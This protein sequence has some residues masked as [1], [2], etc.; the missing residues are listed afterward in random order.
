MNISV[1]GVRAQAHA[2]LNQ[3]PWLLDIERQYGLP[4]GLLIGVGSRETNGHNIVGDDGHGYGVWQRDNRSWPIDRSYLDNVRKQATDAA[5]LL[6]T[7]YNA[8]KDWH[9]A[10][11][12]YN[13][14]LGAVKS[15]VKA[16]KDPDS[17]TTGYD[18]GKDVEQRRQT[19]LPIL[20]GI[21]KP[22]A[23]PALKYYT[24][25]SGDTLS[26][27]ATMNNVSLT[28][29]WNANAHTLDLEAKKRGHV[30]SSRG[31]VIFPGTKVVLP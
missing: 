23:A 5:S 22:K 15:A 16:G 28:A 12:A 27:I 6:R 13:C 2:M 9:G 14:G 3:W 20:P 18:Y 30:G 21:P 19:V 8:L 25:K 29:L 17:R 4:I 24:V 11:S 26:A 31:A 7:N 10:I 1:A